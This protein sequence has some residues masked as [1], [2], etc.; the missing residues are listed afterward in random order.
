MT[1]KTKKTIRDAVLTLRCTPGQ[2][3]A[4]KRHCEANALQMTAWLLELAEREIASPK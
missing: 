1:T 3:L 4:I 2:K